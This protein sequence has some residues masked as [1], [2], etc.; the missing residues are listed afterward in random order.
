MYIE[1]GYSVLNIYSIFL[2]KKQKIIPFK[3]T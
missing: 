1:L 2:G 3:E